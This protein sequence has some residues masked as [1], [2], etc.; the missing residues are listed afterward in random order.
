MGNLAGWLVS[1]AL[2]GMVALLLVKPV[3]CPSASPPETDMRYQYIKAATVEQP[4]SIIVG[5]APTG[6]GNAGDDY[7]QAVELY[8]ANKEVLDKLLKAVYENKPLLGLP[9]SVDQMVEL[10]QAGAGK[11]AMRYTFVHTERKI[12]IRGIYGPAL[13]L[14]TVAKIVLMA[15]D[16][17]ANTGQTDRAIQI[18]KAACVM[19][20]HMFNEGAV[21]DMT[22]RGLAIQAMAAQDLLRLYRDKGMDAEAANASSYERAATAAWTYCGTKRQKLWNTAPKA[23]NLFFIAENDPGRAWRVQAVMSMAVLKFSARRTADRRINKRLITKYMSSDDPII[24]A[25]A[26]S[27]RYLKKSQF[28]TLGAP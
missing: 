5:A 28:N 21:V 19:G 12:E 6:G 1:V 7:A 10:V 13:D 8:E 2:V 3:A 4:I 23:G 15:G 26:K 24:A 16:L 11:A 9:T 20:W 17:Y 27:A 25:A 22:S 14:E 18:R